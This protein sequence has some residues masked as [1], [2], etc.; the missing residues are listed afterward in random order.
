MCM[1]CGRFQELMIV[2]EL[3]WLLIFEVV[4][5]CLCKVNVLGLM[6][7]NVLGHKVLS[8]LRHM[9]ESKYR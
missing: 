7:P 3:M 8:V 4:A 5:S 1:E 2:K 6:I 9:N